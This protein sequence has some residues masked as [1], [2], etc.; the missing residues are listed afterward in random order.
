MRC[1]ALVVAVLLAAL[2]STTAGAVIWSVPGDAATIQGGIDLASAGDTVLVACDTYYE[3]DIM[4]RSGICLLSETGE[5]SCV[6]VDAQHQGRVMYCTTVDHTTSITG[7]TFINGYVSATGGRAEGGGI[8]CSNSSPRITDC[9]FSANTAEALYP[10]AGSGAF[11]GGLYCGSSSSPHLTDCIFG[12][13]V[14]RAYGGTNL[15]GGYGGG[16]C[17]ESSS[18]AELTNCTFA[19]NHAEAN[20]GQMLQAYG[21]GLCMT[22]SSLTLSNCTFNGNSAVA[23]GC[24]LDMRGAGGGIYCG[25]SSPVLAECS[26]D[27]NEASAWPGEPPCF[28]AAYGGGVCCDSSPAILDYCSFLNN[29]AFFPEDYDVGGAAL[30]G[31]MACSGDPHPT[32]T[33]CTF[34]HNLA[35]GEAPQASFGGGIY[36]SW[37]GTQ[38][39]ALNNVIIAFSHHGEAVACQGGVVPALACCDLYGNA[40]G[41]WVG[42]VA[43]QQGVDGNISQDP[44]FCDPGAG[45]FTLRENSP[46]APF[47]PPNPECGLI[48]AWPVG[49]AGLCFVPVMYP[50][51]GETLCAGEPVTI[52]W[53]FNVYCGA[54]VSIELVRAGETCLI[55]AATTEN[56]GEY[57]WIT[58]QCGTETEDYRIR[59]T[60]LETGEADE[61]DASFVIESPCIV[62]VS[63]PNGGE[64]FRVGDA[65]EITWESTPCC[66]DSVSI[67]LRYQDDTC[68]VIT[69]ATP[70]DGTHEWIA[71]AY[72]PETEAYRVRVTNLATS[73][74]DESDAPFVIADYRI[75]GITDIPHDQGRQVRVRWQRELHD[76]AGTDTTV[77]AYSIWRRVDELPRMPGHPASDGALQARAY[78]P[79]DWD[80]VA[81]VPAR[82]ED[83]YGTVCPTLCDS[84]AVEGVCWSTFFVS[85]ETDDPLVYFDTP[86]DSGYSVDNLA[87]APPENLRLESP[88]LLAWDE[89]QAE[90]FDYFSVYGSDGPEFDE[91]TLI[92]H[93]IETSMDVSEAPYD[94]Y[95]VT[96]TD[97]AGNRGDPSTIEAGGSGLAEEPL[98]TAFAL[99]R[100]QGSPGRFPMMLSYDLPRQ[101]HVRLRVCDLSGRLVS[102]LVDGT[103]PPG[104]HLVVWGA[105]RERRINATAGVYFVVMAA[106]DFTATRKAIVIE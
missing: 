13:N 57:S 88:T 35:S 86:P 83:V 55:I 37:A 52:A 78:P 19:G 31:G 33:N 103:Q 44:L 43:D 45:D 6:V 62:T 59:V 20:E 84:T 29:S 3:H 74:Q 15:F 75:T 54:S 22:S 9:I 73:A 69:G 48:G 26:F 71:E 30:G 14:A 49:C 93:T 11:G 61:S 101:E 47:S 46:C 97:F 5:A 66:G 91:A 23:G 40:G 21:G 92:G 95:H 81:S 105:D 12:D 51:G 102:T 64:S 18:S 100:V 77:T 2:L 10:E 68:L 58:E 38:V 7:F 8:Y 1:C 89:S 16:L 99:G 17:A 60:D 90:D 76:H 85:A 72:G 41:D 34:S 50:N 67:E 36:C 24:W 96:A 98:P 104:R 28:G 82:G 56:D 42:C 27:G 94:F 32:L 39:L 4:M 80:F 53:D 79:G 63:H 65:V 70:N 87:P 25:S 106:G